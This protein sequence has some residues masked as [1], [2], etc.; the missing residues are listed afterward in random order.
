MKRV[1]DY[2]QGWRGILLILYV[3]FVL[4]ADIFLSDHDDKIK[5]WLYILVFVVSAAVCPAL[6]KLFR[7]YSI[8]FKPVLT[9]RKRK[10]VWFSVFLLISIAVF[11]LYYAANYPGAFSADSMTQYK[12][13]ITGEYNNWHP[14]LHTLLGFTLP[15]TLT[16]GW[17]GSI[18][19]FQLI[20]FSFAAAYAA[21]TILRHSNIAYAFLSLMFILVS[22]ATAV[23]SMYPWK[24]IPFAIT[25]LLAA[26]YAANA[27]FTKGEW[28]K[29]RSHIAAVVT[30]LV[31]ATVF[32]HN[33]LLFTLPMMIALLLYLNRK[34]AVITGVCF[35]AAVILIE[36]PFYAILKVEQPGDRA[37]EMLG[38][39]VSVIGAVAAKNPQA[40]D[41]DIKE[42]IYSVAPAESWTDG[43]VMGN[44]NTVKFRAG[45]DYHKISEAGAP[46]VIGYMLRCFV[47][48]P[49]EA[50]TGLIAATDIAYTITADDSYWSDV[51]PGIVGNEFG[52]TYQNNPTA[53]GIVSFMMKR[54][55]T[56]MKWIFWYI[57][58]MN[59][60]LIVAALSRLRFRVKAEWERI[61]PALSMLLYNFCTMLLLSGDDFRLFYYTFAVTPVLLLLLMREENKTLIT[62]I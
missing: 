47:E 15:L 55:N 45:T 28:L 59:L 62:P 50:F 7:R 43:Y 51:T 8:R 57:G 52:I 54:L 23:M 14:V 13:A 1:F 37:E 4:D 18:V 2:L 20:A 24:D 35:V 12:Q 48:S 21:Y 46:K 49:K 26:A 6:I 39:P 3:Q 38:V 11:G 17:A 34:A 5:T 44:F 41:D 33:A 60:I 27:W 40:L 36:G 58:A 42:F 9:T 25:T 32:R 16:G 22:P 19:L 10:I 29:K 53:N 56:F 61:L 30:V 31:L